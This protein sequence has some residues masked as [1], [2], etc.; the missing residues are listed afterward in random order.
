MFGKL[1]AKLVGSRNDR[2]LKKLKKQVLKINALEAEDEKLSDEQLKNKTSEFKQRVKDGA[3]LDDILA[4]A[5]ATV[6]EAS[7]RVFNMRHFDVQ[8]LGGMVLHQGKIPRCAPV[9]VKP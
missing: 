2:F 5:F 9:K 3:S 7:K 6:R 8:L 4:E 1:F